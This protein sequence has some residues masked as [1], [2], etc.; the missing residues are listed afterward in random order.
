[1]VDAVLEE[2]CWVQRRVRD[3]P[4][5]VAVYL[6]LAGCLFTQRPLLVTC[7]ALRT[8][9]AGT[10]IDPAGN[11]GRLVLASLMPGPAPA[12]ASSSAPYPST[13]PEAKSAA[14]PAKPSSP[15]S[16]SP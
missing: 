14:Q 2:T 13:G 4:S 3:L 8:A 11:I 9:T 16:S 6:L 5:R 12:P 7:R 15:S 1:M 10:V